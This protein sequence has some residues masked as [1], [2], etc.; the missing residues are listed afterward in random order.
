MVCKICTRTQYTSISGQYWTEVLKNDGGLEEELRKDIRFQIVERHQL[1]HAIA[2]KNSWGDCDW[3]T[4]QTI[5]PVMWVM[6]G[7]GM[8]YRA[9]PCY[10]EF[11]RHQCGRVR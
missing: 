2:W 9:D 1:I 4:L 10:Q 8:D 7:C 3:K 6:L 11:G 5:T